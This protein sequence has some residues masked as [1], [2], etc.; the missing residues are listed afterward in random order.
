MRIA[1]RVF[2]GYFVIVA[3]AGWLLAQVF[4]AE[5]KPGVRQAMEDTL[6][7]TAN[8]L[9]EL[10]TD[11]FIKG[12][13]DDGDFAKR[14]RAMARR[15]YGAQI[16]GFGKRSSQYRIYVADARGIVVFDSDGRDVGKDYSRW[17]DVY[18]TLRGRYGARSTRND[19]AD[20]NS[21]VMH[22]AA[23]IRD[24]DGRIVGVLT[25]AKPNRAIAPFIERSQRAVWRWGA[26]LLGVSL[27]IGLLAAWW[28][29]KQL[30]ALRRYA[31]AVT[32]GERAAPPRAAGEFG[33]LGSALETMRVR[34]EGKQYVEQYVHTLTHE[35][36]SPLAAI[37]GSAEL[38]EGPLDEPDR[39]R[40]VAAIRAQSERLAQMIDKMLALAAV[41]HRQRLEHPEALSLS[42]VIA[43]A[44]AQCDTRLA[45]ADLRLDFDLPAGLPDVRGDRFLLRQA[46]VNLIEN[47]IDFAPRG[48]AIEVQLRADGASQCVAVRD[49]GP[50]IPDYAEG[51][52][53]E[54][55]YS[56]PRPGNGSRSSGLGL[57]FVAEVAALHGGEAV[58]HNREGGGA[59]AEIRLPPGE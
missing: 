2:L 19:Y 3:L 51:R 6:V 1:L 22:V 39:A 48:S 50:G 42:G 15:D 49:R 41:E 14:V 17:N 34:L 21:T 57:P 53:F 31:N 18:L 52:V 33:E 55:F 10:A 11:D 43:D 12:R 54:R 58:L 56:L 13:I 47:A 23:P 25:V 40:F 30:G 7:D 16:W 27:V 46:V 28:L 36:K 45:Q 38:L 44:A 29:S 37:R 4:V 59:V 20:P 26:V 5:V 32:A 9:A 24:V 8:V 35:M